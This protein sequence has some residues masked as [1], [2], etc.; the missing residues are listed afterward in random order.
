MMAIAEAILTVV[1]EAAQTHKVDRVRV[2]IGALH[3]VVPE[4]LRFSF[5]L[6]ADGTEAQDAIVEIEDVPAAFHCR[7]CHAEDRLDGPSFH[8]HA[9]GSPEI[10]IMSGEELTVES[11]E[12]QEG[13]VL[14]RGARI[15]T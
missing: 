6:A 12:R 1:L 7:M 10:T 8:C 3:A 11:V 15:T 14:V 13:A 4:S 9:C 2:K 5:Q